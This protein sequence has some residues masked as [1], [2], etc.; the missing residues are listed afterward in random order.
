MVYAL[1]FAS[2]SVCVVLG[3]YSS[4]QYTSYIISGID[5]YISTYMHIQICETA[6]W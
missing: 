2:A 5:F 6:L 3:A 1:K 4:V